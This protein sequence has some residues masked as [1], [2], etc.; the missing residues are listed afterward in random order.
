MKK[1][2][3]SLTLIIIFILTSLTML[4]S[5]IGI[6]TNRF[7]NFISNKII[8]N[9]N[10]IDLKLTT[11]NFKL[12]LKEIGLFLETKNPQINYRDVLIPAENIK[13]YI[14]FL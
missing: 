1:I 6:E 9:N 11:V 5:T 12:D 13:V 14:D 4:L 2:I 7:N 3:I 10:N 8:Q